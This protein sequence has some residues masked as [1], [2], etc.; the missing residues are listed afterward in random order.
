M[1]KIFQLL[2]FNVLL[3]QTLSE[4]GFLFRHAMNWKNWIA[5]ILHTHYT[6]TFNRNSNKIR[7]ISWNVERNVDDI[8]PYLNLSTIGFHSSPSLCAHLTSTFLLYINTIFSLLTISHTTHSWT[9]R[10]RQHPHN[11]YF[12][13]RKSISENYGYYK[14]RRYCVFVFELIITAVPTT[15]TDTYKQ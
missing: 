4:A 12:Q 11:R 1:Y 9:C 3:S 7:I 15:H 13:Q 8:F 2:F 6:Y 14:L 10:Y 5:S